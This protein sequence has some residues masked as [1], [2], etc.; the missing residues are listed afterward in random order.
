MILLNIERMK[1]MKKNIT[2]LFATI[3]ML[4][5]VLP[6]SMA[7]ASGSEYFTLRSDRTAV[8]PGD[9]ITY[10]VSLSGAKGINTICSGIEY[11]SEILTYISS[12]PCMD[13]SYITYNSVIPAGRSIQSLVKFNGAYDVTDAAVFTVTFK[14]NEDAGSGVY[15]DNNPLVYFSDNPDSG[16]GYPGDLDPT[17]TAPERLTG[18]GAI[19]ITSDPISYYKASLK[20]DKESA[21]IGEEVVYTLS[22][23]DE[24]VIDSYD[25][26]ITYDPYYLKLTNIAGTQVSE[27]N[28]G[29]VRALM[30]S[31]DGNKTVS[32]AIAVLTFTVEKAGAT[33]LFVRVKEYSSEG[34]AY[35]RK[36]Y[37]T[38]CPSLS[39]QGNTVIYAE[40]DKE[41]VSEGE[42][43]K[44]SLKVK[45]ASALDSIMFTFGYDNTKFKLANEPA[46]DRIIPAGIGTALC[47]EEGT[48]NY[49]YLSTSEN[50]FINGEA[51]LMSVELVATQADPNMPDS[52]FTF[53]NVETIPSDIADFQSGFVKLYTRDTAA[54]NAAAESIGSIG[55]I[56]LENYEKKGE[57]I[58]AARALYEALSDAQKAL[59]PSEAVEKLEAAEE[60]Y[61]SYADM[62][63]IKITVT[64]NKLG[65][66]LNAVEQKPLAEHQTVVLA[67]YN[68]S[69]GTLKSVQFTTSDNGEAAIAADIS[70][71]VCRAFVWNSAEGM[72]PY[73]SVEYV[74]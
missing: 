11:N 37:M 60:A 71:T 13:Y 15:S 9:E 34:L 55:E 25:F 62:K 44:I 41:S 3:C 50:G 57:A 59:V 22:I 47:P 19:E 65:Y 63:D 64:K 58:A 66:I 28:T 48:I 20:P 12:V 5:S 4:F 14:V 74:Y 40:P 16:V 29:T 56:T 30:V 54:A 36:F 10:T 26:E 67:V 2:A 23:D 8:C 45:D 17:A 35:A 42:T 27:S 72:K 61:K 38:D 32:G 49:A 24:A 33:A 1:R 39:I 51:E 7:A 52:E 6:C 43:V 69:D 73:E 68:S 70:S 31:A 53:T 46:S 18:S 21:E